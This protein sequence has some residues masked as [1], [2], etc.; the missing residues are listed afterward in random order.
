MTVRTLA[1]LIRYSLIIGAVSFCCAALVQAKGDITGWEADSEYNKL[2]NYKERDTIRGH[3][4]KFVKVKPLKGMAPGTAFTLDEGGGDTVL[5]HVCPES[6]ATVRETGLKPGE[7]LKVK[8]AWAEIGDESVFLAAKIRRESGS[9]YKVRL[10]K[11]GTPFWTMAPERL[12]K[13][14]AE[15][16]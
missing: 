9:A 1:R 14:L 4:V 8:G 11:D 5:V 3:I 10:T 13:E 7:W 12:A 15:T 16:E 6:Y 2:Y